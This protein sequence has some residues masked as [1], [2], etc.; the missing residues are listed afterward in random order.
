[1]ETVDV[2]QFPESDPPPQLPIGDKE[3][4]ACLKCHSVITAGQYARDGCQVCGTGGVGHE[5][6]HNYAT[7]RFSGFVGIISAEQSWVAKLIGCGKMPTGVYAAHVEPDDE[8]DGD[9]DDSDAVGDEDDRY[10][11]E[12][13]E[14]EEGKSSAGDRKSTNYREDSTDKFLESVLRN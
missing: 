5:E 9:D 13:P 4:V 2:A 8:D 11:E 10:E 14:K 7:A 3:H 6:L 1:M 12:K